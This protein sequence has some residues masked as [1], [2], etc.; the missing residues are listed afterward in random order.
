MGTFWEFYEFEEADGGKPFADWLDGLAD[1]KAEGHIEEKILH[2]ERMEFHNENLIKPYKG[3]LGIFE[4]KASRKNIMYRPLMCKHPKDGR[5]FVFLEGAIE[6]N[7]KIKPGHLTRA[8]NRR[9]QL[10]KDHTRAKP[11]E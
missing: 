9:N 4:F 10:L 11:R 3:A 5:I 7:D 8:K 6:V 2:A 1:P